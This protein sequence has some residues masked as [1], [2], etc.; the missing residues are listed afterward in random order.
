MIT[1]SLRRLRSEIERRRSYLKPGAGGRHV[2]LLIRRMRFA[3]KRGY[4][5]QSEFVAIGRTKT[6]R[7]SVLLKANTSTKIREVTRFAYSATNEKQ[8]I[9][10]LCT[11]R[12]VAVPRASCL[13]AWVYPDKWGVIDVRAWKVLVHYKAVNTRVEGR[14]LGPNQWVTYVKILN[15]LS[16]ALRVTPRAID[17][18]LYRHY[19]DLFPKR[20]RRK[21]GWRG[22]FG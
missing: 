12:G 19:D 6:L 11:L 21:T 8:R 20:R 1:P 10:R 14:N 5:N 17:V 9:E 13:L 7:K 22:C 2:D 3:A 18:W 16:E 15:E 4:L